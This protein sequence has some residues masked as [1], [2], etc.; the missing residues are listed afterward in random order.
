MVLKRKLPVEV[1]DE[2]LSRAK[3]LLCQQLSRHTSHFHT[4]KEEQRLRVIL[5]ATFKQKK[6]NSVIVI[7]DQESGKEQFVSAVIDSYTR[8]DDAVSSASS[9]S[10][11]TSANSSTP[12]LAPVKFRVARIKGMVDGNDNLAFHTLAKQL[13][14]QKTSDRKFDANLDFVGQALRTSYSQGTPTIIV[15]EDI[16]EFVRRKKQLLLYTLFD[17]M[18]RSDL[19]FAVVGITHK[20]PHLLTL[21]HAAVT[22]NQCS[23]PNLLHTPSNRIYSFR[24]ISIR[25]S[26]SVWCLV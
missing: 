7:G 19:L 4:K 22:T 9:S 8:P 18:H 15:I 13:Y 20:V 3:T 23:P 26:R 1:N 21:L 11:T 12:A 5:D 6:S 24:R 16:H 2:I 14:V 10:S 25:V 17:L